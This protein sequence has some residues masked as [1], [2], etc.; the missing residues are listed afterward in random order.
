MTNLS[1]LLPNLKWRKTKST[2]STK[3]LNDPSQPVTIQEI[4]LDLVRGHFPDISEAFFEDEAE[5]TLKL[6]ELVMVKHYHSIAIRV[7]DHTVILDVFADIKAG[8][9]DVVGSRLE[10]K[11]R[12]GRYTNSKESFEH[13]KEWISECLT[14]HACPRPGT[15]RVMLPK[16]LLVVEGALDDPV[17]LIETRGDEYPY[18]CLS[19]RW[20]NPTHKQL[21]TTTRT[22]DSHMSKIEWESLPATFRDAVTVCRSMDVKYLWIDSLCIL[23]SFAEMTPSELEATRHDFALENSNMA[24]TYQN[25]HFTISADLSDHMDSG[26]FSRDPVHEYNKDVT[27]DK[28]RVASVYIRRPIDHYREDVPNLEARGWT[29]QEFLLPPRV[30]HFGNFDITWRCKTRITCECGH[31]DRQKR[32]QAAWHRY[33]FIED[34]A[35]PPPDDSEGAL[36]W[37]EQVVHEYTSRQL[38]NAADKLPAL[39]GLAQQRK[40]IRGGLYLAGLWRDSLIH[41]LCWYHVSNYNVPTSGG[42]G[43]RP[44]HY[45]APSWSWAAVDTDSGCSWWWMGSIGLHSIMPDDEPKQACRI[46][47]VSCEPATSDLTG[48]VQSGFLDIKTSLAPAEICRDPRGEVSWTIHKLDPSLTLEFFKPDCV[49]ED[50]GLSLGDQVFCAPIAGFG[51]IREVE[52]AC[53][54]LKQIDGDIYQ[55]V[56]FCIISGERADLQSCHEDTRRPDL[57]DFAWTGNVQVQIR[58]V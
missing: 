43:H 47:Q 53:L 33:H 45:R 34:A 35:R 50:D 10:R 36:E 54:A 13:A 40:Q 31:L 57:G 17:R 46:I 39:S 37:W 28:G 44:Q 15:S 21:K 32:R 4:A 16:R 58:I 9:F 29:L 56:G 2:A 11:Y 52:C 5:E 14:T 7:A 27:T 23:Q 18:V 38:T 8:V 6:E 51:N 25:S 49:L 19:H 48:E 3:S 41:D 24:R 55:R 26:F 12:V 42:V 30:L 22:L 20:G 1:A